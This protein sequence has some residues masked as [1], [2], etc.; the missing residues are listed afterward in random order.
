MTTKPQ[1]NH[2]EQ[3]ERLPNHGEDKVLF[4]MPG[5]PPALT[6]DPAVVGK[7]VLTLRW[8]LINRTLIAPSRHLKTLRARRF[9]P[10]L[11]SWCR[12][13]IDWT[14]LEGAEALP[15]GVL[16]IEV[17]ELGHAL[18]R[19][20]PFEEMANRSISMLFDRACCAAP[21]LDPVDQSLPLAQRLSPEG[22]RMQPGDAVAAEVLWI[23]DT[24][25]SSATLIT[26]EH[27]ELS[28]INSLAYDL[29]TT[30]NFTCNRA[31]LDLSNAAHQH[32]ALDLVV[33][34]QNAGLDLVLVSDEYGVVFADTSKEPG[35]AVR[36]LKDQYDRLTEVTARKRTHTRLAWRPAQPR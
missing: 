26:S 32:Q 8:R 27:H 36:A 34:A 16:V 35:A 22:G 17:D 4:E 25:N 7:P 31:G 1:N 19:I 29:M 6:V 10:G 3:E 24:N 33:Q 28:G 20:E 30:K 2:N 18:M 23:I 15:D 21:T 12:Q 9:A 11:D 5:Q 14:L 13:H